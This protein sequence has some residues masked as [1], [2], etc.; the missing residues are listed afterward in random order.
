MIPTYIALLL[1]QQ[2]SDF[3]LADVSYIEATNSK[4]SKTFFCKLFSNSMTR[5]LEPDLWMVCFF[6]SV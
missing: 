2:P 4:V 6:Q 5:H 1:N 3:W